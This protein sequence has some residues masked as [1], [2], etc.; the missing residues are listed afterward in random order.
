MR[1]RLGIITLF[2]LLFVVFIAIWNYSF[3]EGLEEAYIPLSSDSEVPFIPTEAGVFQRSE[4]ALDYVNMPIDEEYQRSLEDYYNNRAF[5]GGPP[6]IPHPVSNEISMGENSCLK[7][8]QNGGFV[9]KFDAYTPI[10]PHPELV[11]CRQC[12]VAS[13]TESVF[14][15]TNFNKGTVPGVGSNNALLGGPP[16]IPHPI[17]LRESCLS[18]HA[19]PA[20]P[21]EIRVTHPER[22]N[23]R[24]CH[25][26]NNKIEKNT[27][28]FTRNMN[29]DQ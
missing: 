19:G 10:T 28:V 16:V 22:I 17:H 12:H 6:T 15:D 14:Q 5:Y 7:C 20:A 9:E 3:Q 29:N 24:Q 8:H 13:N 23:C 18:C 4:Y 1:K 11:N 26:L 25:A 27:S 2:T 21:K